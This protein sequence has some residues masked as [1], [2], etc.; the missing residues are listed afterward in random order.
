MLGKTSMPRCLV[1][2]TARD[3]RSQLLAQ[4]IAA[5]LPSRG[6]R[7]ASCASSSAV[8]SVPLE[9]VD[10]LVLVTPWLTEP[11]AGDVEAVI[12]RR[13][14]PLALLPTGLLGIVSAA[15]S[16]VGPGRAT[17]LPEH[18]AARCLAA[19]TSRARR[20]AAAGIARV[21]MERERVAGFD[22]A[23]VGDATARAPSG[24][25][26]SDW[27]GLDRFVDDFIAATRA[28]LYPVAAG[29]G[30]GALRGARASTRPPVPPLTAGCWRRS[31]R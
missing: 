24:A 6:A 3:P 12:A 26:F 2:F 4:Y 21:A 18:L 11:H 30:S 5:V 22:V 20:L 9:R 29:G 1:V 17:E 19:A 31:T 15:A 25:E 14:A 16:A 13:G 23:R 27:L 28:A 8:E 7:A 10:A